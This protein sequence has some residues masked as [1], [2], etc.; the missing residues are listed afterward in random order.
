MTTDI[1]TIMA[2][3]TVEL[4]LSYKKLKAYIR[5]QITDTLHIKIDIL[6]DYS[7]HGSIRITNICRCVLSLEEELQYKHKLQPK[8][9]S[10]N[11][12][13]QSQR[14]KVIDE[15]MS[16]LISEIYHHLVAEYNLKPITLKL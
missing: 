9:T 13:M 4:Q 11:E 2:T 5:S 16:I 7:V 6:P 15:V 1:K 8:E 3:I 12:F 14:N 10:S